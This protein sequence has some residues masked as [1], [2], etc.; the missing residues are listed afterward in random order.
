MGTDV[1]PSAISITDGLRSCHEKKVDKQISQQILCII[2]KNRFVLTIGTKGL[3]I[4][5][6]FNFTCM[7]TNK[8]GMGR[9]GLD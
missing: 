9:H 5:M 8:H 4:F 3:Q 2:V 6:A 1:M 7:N